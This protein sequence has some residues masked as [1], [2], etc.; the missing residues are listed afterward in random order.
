MFA[1]VMAR[2]LVD[3]GCAPFFVARIPCDALELMAAGWLSI[4]AVLAGSADANV[5]APVVELVGVCVIGVGSGW[6]RNDVAVHVDGRL[7][8][9]GIANHSGDVSGYGDVPLEFIEAVE[10][11]VVDERETSVIEADSFHWMMGVCGDR[12]EADSASRQV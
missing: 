11:L 4:A 3:D 7:L 10:V 2:F 6:R 8:P 9:A 5:G 1:E 12:A